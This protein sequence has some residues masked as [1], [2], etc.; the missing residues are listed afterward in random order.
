MLKYI[1]K[2]HNPYLSL[3][4]WYASTFQTRTGQRSTASWTPCVSGS[5][6]LQVVSPMVGDTHGVFV[7]NVYFTV[8]SVKLTQCTQTAYFLPTK[9]RVSKWLHIIIILLFG[10]WPPL[11]KRIEVNQSM[12]GCN[13]AGRS[14]KKKDRQFWGHLCE[15]E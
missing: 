5:A 2:I 7:T 12:I 6:N 3:Q 4:P 14:R 15:Q 11:T 10:D 9:Y 13:A 8:E 1:Y